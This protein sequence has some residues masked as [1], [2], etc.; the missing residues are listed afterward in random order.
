MST[1]ISRSCAIALAGA[2]LFVGGGALAQ[3]APAAGA[4]QQQQQQP[5][6]PI[7]AE[8][9]AVQPEWTKV[10]GEDPQTNTEMCYTTRDFGVSRSG[11]GAQPVL[12]LAHL[13]RKGHATRR[14]SVPACRPASS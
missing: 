12:A 5:Q 2:L 7:A 1:H 14:S 10:C 3:Q 8:L 11:R 6:G 13:R 9:V 4:A